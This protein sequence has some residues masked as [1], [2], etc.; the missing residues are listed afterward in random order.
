MSFNIQSSDARENF[1]T[2]ARLI[3]QANGFMKPN[4]KGGAPIP[5]ISRI[6]L[7]QLTQGY[8]CTMC[9][10]NPQ[11][12]I[13][14]FSM[15]DTQQVSGSPVIPL[16]RLL[17]M[18]DSFV[19]SSM[20]YFLMSYWFTGTQ[21]TPNYA[22]TTYAT[23]LTYASRF[24]D[25]NAF[26]GPF[27]DPGMTMFWSPGA[28]ISIE[29]DKKVVIPYWDVLK[30]LKVPQQQATMIPTS[31]TPFSQWPFFQDEYDGSTD[32]YFPVEPTVVF[33][34]GRQNIVKLNLTANIPSTINPFTYSGYGTSFVMKACIVFHGILAQ[35]S[36]SVK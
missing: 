11:Q 8:L 33:G 34:G 10:V 24:H 32:G 4:P 25:N 19:V 30:H 21:Q 29:V 35:N 1:R 3:A 12:S 15:V 27:M 26:G 18:Q 9:D 17:S 20:S 13:L 28:Y 31:A 16:M 36:T 5:D 6:D 22:I 23:P 2:A 14:Q 7:Q